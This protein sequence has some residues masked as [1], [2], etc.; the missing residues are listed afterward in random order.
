LVEGGLTGKMI[1][2]MSDEPGIIRVIDDDGQLV[3]PT[4]MNEDGEDDGW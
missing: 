3:P 1:R 4:V 2:S